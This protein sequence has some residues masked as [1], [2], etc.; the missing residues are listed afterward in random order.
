M[1][2]YKKGAR[3]ERELCSMLEDMGY[4][5]VRSAGSGLMKSPDIVAAKNGRVLPLNVNSG[6][7][8]EI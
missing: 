8:E 4:A 6:K 7:V 5:I 2:K 3:A 1:S